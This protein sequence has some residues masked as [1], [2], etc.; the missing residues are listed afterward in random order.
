M[1]RLRREGNNSRNLKCNKQS[2]NLCWRHK[3]IWVW[4]YEIISIIRI[5]L[6][7]KY[8][9]L[10]NSWKLYNYTLCIKNLEILEFILYNCHEFD[11]IGVFVIDYKYEK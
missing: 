5:L 9:N 11:V 7:I 10:H 8:A 6:V 4:E 1:I 2:I 3:I